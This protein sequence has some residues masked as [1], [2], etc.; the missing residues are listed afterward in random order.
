M[1][2]SLCRTQDVEEAKRLKELREKEA[3]M[4]AAEVALRARLA[5]LEAR[6]KEA[7]EALAK[8]EEERK[9]C[10]DMK[11]WLRSLRK[12]LLWVTE[13]GLHGWYC[14]MEICCRSGYDTGGERQRQAHL[15]AHDLQAAVGER[16]A[17]ARAHT[18]ARE[19]RSE[20]GFAAEEAQAAQA[21]AEA[22]EKRSKELEAQAEAVQREAASVQAAAQASLAV[23]DRAWRIVW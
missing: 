20:A 8:A 18:E 14:V 15:N 13:L 19:A 22:R 23:G 5:A 7:G 21:K 2:M 16:A 1:S 17:A 10:L 9:V 4:G 3:E 11:A 12:G 6:E